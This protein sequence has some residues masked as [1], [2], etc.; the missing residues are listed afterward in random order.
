MR[1]TAQTEPKATRDLSTYLTGKL[2]QPLDVTKHADQFTSGI[3]DVTVA[4]QGFTTWLELKMLK[5]GKSLDSEL[6]DDQLLYCRRLEGATNRRCWIVVWNL[7][8]RANPRTE[9]YAPSLVVRMRR[10]SALA[11][12]VLPEAGES[13]LKYRQR[14]L[15]YGKYLVVDG[16]SHA[17][18]VDLIRITHRF[19][20]STADSPG[21]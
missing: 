9:I 21:R 18:V 3:P 15:D 8:D 20:W 1:S 6:G 11:T 7:R 13:V 12:P 17:A 19:G 16:V 4:W 2:P 10:E 5:P 14:A